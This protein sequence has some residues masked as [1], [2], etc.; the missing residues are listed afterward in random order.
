MLVRQW[1]SDPLS[2]VYD[3][4]SGDTHVLDALLV[5]LLQLTGQ[6]HGRTVEDL[7]LDLADVF[8]ERDAESAR[9][10]IRSGLATLEQM[11][12]VEQKSR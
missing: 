12:L 1:E 3:P 7:A 8:A 10:A 2:L 11:G 4:L 6:A 5:E 9:E